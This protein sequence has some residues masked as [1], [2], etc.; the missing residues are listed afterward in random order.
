MKLLPILLLAGLATPALAG[1]LGDRTCADAEVAG[2]IVHQD[3]KT[4][5]SPPGFIGTD[6]LLLI[7]FDVRRVRFGSIHKGRHRIRA[8]APEWLNGDG[9][10]ALYLRREGKDWWIADCRDR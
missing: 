8:I 2:R 5:P 4:L 1:A 10:V 6:V 3:Y 9:D 7:D